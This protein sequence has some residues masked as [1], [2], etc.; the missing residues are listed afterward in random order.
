MLWRV[1]STAERAMLGNCRGGEVC[2][3]LVW[4]GMT[5]RE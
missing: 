2:G 4:G 3:R 1:V 5:I